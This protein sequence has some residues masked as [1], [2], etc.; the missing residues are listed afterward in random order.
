[1]LRGG[2]GIFYGP[3]QTEDQIQ[4]IES[5]RISSTLSSGPL[6]TFNPDQTAAIN[7]IIAN[8]TN[9]PNNRAFQPRAYAPEYVVPEKIYSYT[10]SVQQELP[11]KLV[12]T[13]AY[14][15]SQGRNLFLRGLSN[16]LRDGNAVIADG[17]AIPTNA[18]VVNRTNA[19]DRVIGVTTIRQFSIVSGTSVQN[20]FAEIDTKTSGGSDSYNA[21]QLT[22]ARRIGTGL[23]LNSQYTFSKSFGNTSG[24]NEARTAAEPFGGPVRPSGD[25]NN[26]DADRG[27]NNFDVRHTF[28]L[29]A[30][31]DLPIGSRKRFD[32][33][34]V[35]NAV[36]G[37]WEVGTIMN[38]RS[39]LPIDVTI[40][41]PDVVA[42]C[43]AASCVVND[44]ATTT[45]TVQQ[46]FTVQLPSVSGTQALPT[47]FIAVVNGP[48]GGSSRQTRRPDLLPG[49]NPFLNGDRNFLN[50]AA[51]AIPAA[52]TF[53]NLARNALK[54]PDF[55]QFDLVLNRRFKFNET[56]SLEFRTEI[57]NVFNQANF[58]NPAST[59]NVALPTL[60]FNTT[61]NAF[62]L[63]SGL[64]PG[65]AFTPAAAGPTFGLL[66]Q[67]VERTV[68]LGTNRQ[69]QFALRLNF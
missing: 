22:L 43:A 56:T 17:T 16:V 20:P 27:Y 49:V 19:D 1:M 33:G 5:D 68:G 18:G 32:L 48:G 65:Q 13:V 10:A 67:T 21:L 11:Y 55:K 28:N 36:F 54:G 12:G 4:P 25:I 60:T 42:V 62:V 57:F 40:T 2:F 34:S 9:N 38:M 39:G 31:Y 23:T 69:I 59:L 64:Q 7:A 29:S 6:L 53:G 51:F 45:R 37:N 46:G 61:A 24:S 66:R 15:G 63:G 35:G 58:A 3:G 14:V 30:V 52:G 47:G 41:R 26:Y 44:S 50:P 8:F